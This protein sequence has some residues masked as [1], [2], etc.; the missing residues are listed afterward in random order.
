MSTEPIVSE[1]DVFEMLDRLLG[2][3]RTFDW[4]SFYEPTYSASRDCS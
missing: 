2:E 4:D 3:H 1:D